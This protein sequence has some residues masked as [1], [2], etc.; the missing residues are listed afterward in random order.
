MSTATADIR[1]QLLDRFPP[2]AALAS[3]DLD[4]LLREAA[5][6]EVPEGTRMFDANQPCTGF[7]LLLDGCVRVSKIAPNG[8]EIV[9]YRVEPG[10]VCVLSGG[11]LL[12]HAPHSA[13]GTSEGTVRLMMIPSPLFD[14]L[15]RES[16]PFRNFV[17]GMYGTRLAEVMAVVEDVAFRRLDARLADLLVTR[18]PVIQ[19]T[20][21]RLAEELG[22]VREVVSRV[23]RSF[24]QRG[25]I[26]LARERV[27]VLDPAALAAFA[28]E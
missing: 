10:Q 14:A 13:T 20:H 8:R 21:Q 17:F 16:A 5:P 1:R 27:T 26:A 18:G 3:P 19:D 2:L 15:I 7:P 23:L 6:R 12:G 28:G 22:S 24:E 25:W 11:C 4:R 9:L